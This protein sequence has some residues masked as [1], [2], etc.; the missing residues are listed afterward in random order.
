MGWAS[1][2][3]AFLQVVTGPVLTLMRDGSSELNST[4]IPVRRDSS[5]PS[6]L[7]EAPHP[8]GKMHIL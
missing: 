2:S 8:T 1:A 5:P 6:Q 3:L 7:F 4:F